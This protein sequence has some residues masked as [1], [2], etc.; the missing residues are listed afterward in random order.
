MRN[1]AGGKVIGY[2]DGEGLDTMFSSPQGMA[3]NPLTGDIYLADSDN[4]VIR[5]INS[6]GN[7]LILLYFLLSYDW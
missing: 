6:K 2:K 5:K 4:H 3:V 7:S 1:I